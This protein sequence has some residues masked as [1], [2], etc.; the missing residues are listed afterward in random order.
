MDVL[1]LSTASDGRVVL[2]ALDLLPHTVHTA[3]PAVAAF[4]SATACDVV[5]VDGRTQP[6]AAAQ[7]ATLL[8]A[9]D[10]GIPVVAVVDEAALD[11]VVAGAFDQLLLTTAGPAEADARLRLS[12]RHRAPAESD[13]VDDAVV[14]R[15]GPFE[16]DQHAYTITIGTEPLPLTHHEFEVFRALLAHAGRPLSRERLLGALGG[17]D[18]SPRA[19]DCHV[20]ALRS[21]L[22]PHRT[23]I[24]TVRGLG[25]L[26]V[27]A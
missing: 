18:A 16:L 23:S 22:G 15:V 17:P 9:T 19:I 6:R 11:A 4:L 3:P 10:R 21:K 2:P 7:L 25:Y 20:R 26:A 1:V 14:L 24:R 8:A 12:Q 5:L 13:R 27:T